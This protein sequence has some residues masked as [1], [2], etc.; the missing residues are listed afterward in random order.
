MSSREDSVST[1]H[2]KSIAKAIRVL[3]IVCGSPRHLSIREIAAQ[4]DY[5]LATTHRVLTTLRQVGA[6]DAVS[7]HRFALGPRL[8][9]LHGRLAADL[10]QTRQTVA[11]QLERLLQEPGVSARLSLFADDGLVIIA[12]CDNGAHHR[13]RS[14]IGGHY[15]AYCTAPGKMLLAALPSDDFDRYLSTVPLQPM[16]HNTIVEIKQLKQ[17]IGRV[18]AVGYALDDE[19]Y[20]DGVRCVSVAVPVSGPGEIA[21][22]SLASDSVT[23][24]EMIESIMPRLTAQ[25]KTLASKLPK[26]P[27]GLRALIDNRQ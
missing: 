2:N 10:T 17:E 21:A 24:R 27:R 9:E 16:T 7:E 4:A 22:L 1:R 15:Q 3:E 26:Q 13:F 11:Q 25:A 6:L 14:R 18:R 19:E 8:V 12:G 23:S 20:L 5:S